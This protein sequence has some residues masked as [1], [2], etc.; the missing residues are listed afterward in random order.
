MD[1]QGKTRMITG[2]AT[3]IRAGYRRDLAAR[4]APCNITGRR[5][6]V[7]D[8][9]CGGQYDPDGDGRAQRKTDVG[10]AKIARSRPKPRP[11]QICIPTPVLPRARPCIR[12][13][14]NSG[15]NMMS[16]NLGRAFSYDN[17]ES[18]KDMRGHRMGRV[19]CDLFHAGFA[20]GLPA[21]RPTAA[22]KH[23]MIG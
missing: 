23:G 1:I 11:I 12:R 19:I 10:G 17:R 8:E 9:V 15:A 7:L 16:T 6:E 4:G 2:A 13:I 14:W 5:Q 21:R 18:L 3:G 20:A 22:S